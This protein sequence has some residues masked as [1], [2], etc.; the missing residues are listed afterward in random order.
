MRATTL[1]TL[2]LG[3]VLM[4]GQ[5][6]RAD[7]CRETVDSNGI[8]WRWTPK[9]FVVEERQV[10]IPG[11]YEVR[12]EQ[13]TDPGRWEN[14]ERQVWVPAT[15]VYERRARPTAAVSIPFSIKHRPGRVN[16]GT[17][18]TCE[19]VAVTRPGYW[20]T[21]CER[22]WVPG[23][24]RTVERQVWIPARTECR[25]VTVE[26]PGFWTQIESRTCEQPRGT[27]VVV[28]FGR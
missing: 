9:T 27:R 3:A 22:V 8:R 19:T 14:R 15:V 18:T 21:V 20:K 17:T 16:I 11:H 10:T 13:V 26:K 2:A 23:C 28:R 25:Q 6:A 1:T 12:C 4:L 5:A 24:T 7:E